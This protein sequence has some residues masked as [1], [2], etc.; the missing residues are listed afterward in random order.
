MEKQMKHTELPWD[1]IPPL[2]EGD[3]AI[4]SQHVNESGNFY[5]ASVPN[6]SE[7]APFN[8]CFIVRACNCHHELVAALRD[9]LAVIDCSDFAGGECVPAARAALAKAEGKG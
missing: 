7:M 3:Y 6:T 1:I 5:I 2:G 9:I 4:L 8:A